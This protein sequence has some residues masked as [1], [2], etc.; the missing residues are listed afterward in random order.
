MDPGV[1]KAV[2]SPPPADSTAHQPFRRLP[3]RSTAREGVL[4]LGVN[5]GDRLGKTGYAFTGKMPTVRNERCLEPQRCGALL[6]AK[7]GV[8][9]ELK[10]PANLNINALEAI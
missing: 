9:G 2:P 6:K 1:G 4:F 8:P 10:K 7:H 3:G 5:V